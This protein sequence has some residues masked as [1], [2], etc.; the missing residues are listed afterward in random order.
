MTTFLKIRRDLRR[1]HFKLTIHARERM[2]DRSIFEG[3]IINVGLSCF[4]QFYSKK[5][6]SYNFTGYALDER[7]VTVACDYDN[8]TLIITMFLEG[9]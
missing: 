1:G 2:D 5:H 7:V 4:D 8:E 3:D 6:E 9:D